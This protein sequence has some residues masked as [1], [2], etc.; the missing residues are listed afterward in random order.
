[1]MIMKGRKTLAGILTASALCGGLLL[2][3]PGCGPSSQNVTAP[4][5]VNNAPPGGGSADEY[6]KR[7]QEIKGGG[8]KSGGPPQMGQPPK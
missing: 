6:A 1:M 8:A 5:P 4:A 3:T 7:M 2:V